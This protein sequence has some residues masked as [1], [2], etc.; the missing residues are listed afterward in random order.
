MKSLYSVEVGTD[1]R[2]NG[3]QRESLI[4]LVVVYSDGSFLF[5]EHGTGKE[6]RFSTWSFGDFLRMGVLVPKRPAPA[7]LL[8]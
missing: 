6:I 7:D 4:Q 5:R 8:T 3:Y 2:N 1:Y